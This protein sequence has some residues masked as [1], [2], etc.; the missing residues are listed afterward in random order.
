VR[1]A[2][3]G[4][5]LFPLTAV[6]GGS[7]SGTAAQRSEVAPITAGTQ[8][9]V[10][11][12]AA[13]DVGDCYGT[14]D[15]ATAALLA[16]RP[17]D[18]IFALGDLA[19]ESGTTQEFA[20]CFAP[21]WGAHTARI[22]PVPGNH[23]YLQPGADPYYAYFSTRAGPYGLG[24]YSFDLGAWH[25]I[26]LN[27]ERDIQDSGAQLN[28]LR[29]DL[30]ANTRPCVLA[31]WHKPRFTKADYDDDPGMQPFWSALASAGGDVVLTAHDHNYQRYKPLD[32]SGGFADGGTREFVVGTG[33]MRLDELRPDVRRDAGS[34]TWGLL[35]L[36]L[37][38]DGYDWRFL[39]VDEVFTDTGSGRCR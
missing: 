25:L 2:L 16:E 28:W 9:V 35:E 17:D 39:P 14:G 38:P 30:A 22:Y 15:E 4:I 31:F 36:T 27:S 37:R 6:C 23:E 18:P 12:L 5:A 11:M 24:Y 20:N 19:Y 34:T 7:G 32:A 8:P 29:A 1:Y 3:L 13:G 33:G 21:T 10:T 26:A